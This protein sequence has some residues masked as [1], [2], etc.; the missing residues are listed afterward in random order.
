[1]ILK[2]LNV[3]IEAHNE[4]EI[5]ALKK[6]GFYPISEAPAKAVTAQNDNG[7]II[8]K[9]QPETPPE[10]EIDVNDLTKKELVELAE[11]MGLK[12]KGLN[13]SQIIDVITKG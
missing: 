7:G 5:K 2:R 8:I 3:E 11:D 9:E 13:K 6:Q 12:V 1:M 4:T 10:P